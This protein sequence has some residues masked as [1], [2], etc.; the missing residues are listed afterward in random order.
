MSFN[1]GRPYKWQEILDGLNAHNAPPYY[2][3]R[4]RTDD[5]VVAAC[6]VI[7]VNPRAPYEII[8]ANGPLIRRYA[9]KF[10]R[11]SDPIDVFVQEADGKWYYRGKFK[12]AGESKDANEIK[13][14]AQQ[15]NRRNLYK[16]LFLQEVTT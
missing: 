14:R 8:P 16:I 11:Q 9:D 1:K 6:L 3:L 13:L 12:L 7:G 10:C 4:R 5:A 15:A 2:L